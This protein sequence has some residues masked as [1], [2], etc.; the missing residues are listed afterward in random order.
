[1]FKKCS[2]EHI[3]DIPIG[4]VKPSESQM[5]AEIIATV[6]FLQLKGSLQ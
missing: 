1:M 4:V 5:A 6:R 2:K 3:N